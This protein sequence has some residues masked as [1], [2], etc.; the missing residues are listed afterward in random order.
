VITIVMVGVP[1]GQRV[2]GFLLV[3]VELPLIFL[4]ISIVTI[5]IGVLLRKTFRDD[6]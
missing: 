4:T 5:I 3:R 1:I 6:T 2:M